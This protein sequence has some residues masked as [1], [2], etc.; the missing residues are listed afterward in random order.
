MRPEARLTR[1]FLFLELKRFRN[2]RGPGRNF[3]AE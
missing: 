3:H 1:A 2:C